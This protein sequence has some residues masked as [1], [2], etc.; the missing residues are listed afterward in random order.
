MSVR[1]TLQMTVL[2][3]LETST[4]LPID[5]VLTCMNALFWISEFVYCCSLMD[6]EIEKV[7][8]ACLLTTV[9]CRYVKMSEWTGRVRNPVP[10]LSP[11][12]LRG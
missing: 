7:V 2:R 3:C 1:L 11:C 12:I 5:A 10:V 8:L 9:I 4:T 6:S